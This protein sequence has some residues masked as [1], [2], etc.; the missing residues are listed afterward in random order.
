ML[1]VAYI[2][3]GLLVAWVST[4][5]LVHEDLQDIKRHGYY[6]FNSM[7]YKMTG[8]RLCVHILLGLT[9]G[10]MWPCTVASALVISGIMRIHTFA[11]KQKGFDA[12]KLATSLFGSP[13][14]KKNNA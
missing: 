11:K 9:M 13:K 1:I 2:I 6:G 12:Q 3:I 7:D 14:D 8:G 4:R 10:A 5:A